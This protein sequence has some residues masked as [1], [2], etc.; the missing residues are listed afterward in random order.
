MPPSPRIRLERKGGLA[1]LWIDN[2]PRNAFRLSMISELAERIPELEKDDEVRAVV[3]T[4]E[5]PF[6]SGLDMEDWAALPAK[7]AQ[8]WI[9]RGQD[10]FWALEHLTKPTVAA[11]AGP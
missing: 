4:G 2:P 9:T 8:E 5:G 3:V 11:V 1:I 7:A 10:A 6:S